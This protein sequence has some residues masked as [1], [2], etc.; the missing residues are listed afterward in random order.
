MINNYLKMKPI[1]IFTKRFLSQNSSFKMT[2]INN[3]I[4]FNSF[5]VTRAFTSNTQY[6]IYERYKNLS[7]EEKRKQQREKRRER[8]YF[9]ILNLD[10]EESCK[11]R[12]LMIKH[13][14]ISTSSHQIS[15]KKPVEREP[16]LILKEQ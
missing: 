11:N 13:S 7:N 2:R 8:L 15:S 1:T 4:V 10:L 14:K 5:K 9:K 12:E 3:Q 6:D 16:N